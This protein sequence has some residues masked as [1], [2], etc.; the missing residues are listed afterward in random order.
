MKWPSWL[1]VGSFTGAHFLVLHPL[2]VR[3]KLTSWVSTVVGE[4]WCS[5]SQHLWV[6]LTWKHLGWYSASSFNSL[7]SAHQKQQGLFYLG[8]LPGPPLG[9]L[10]HTTAQRQLHTASLT[11]LPA[12]LPKQPGSGH[13][14]LLRTSCF[15]ACLVQATSSKN[16]LHT[17]MEN[18]GTQGKQWPTVLRPFSH[19]FGTP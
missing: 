15:Q 5:S 7:T 1:S 12:L 16:P 10:P 14:L 3:L 2:I 17:C 9:F 8:E 4:G 13:P 18:G 6:L 11:A 19:S